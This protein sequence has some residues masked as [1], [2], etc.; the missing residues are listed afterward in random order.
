MEPAQ[1]SMPVKQD[2]LA[3][4]DATPAATM[5]TTLACLE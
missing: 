2:I 3:F 5:G 1:H 4:S